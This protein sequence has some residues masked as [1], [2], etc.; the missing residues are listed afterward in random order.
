SFLSINENEVSDTEAE[1][2]NV[3]PDSQHVL[4]PGS[5]FRAVDRTV[6]L[7]NGD[8]VTSQST[9]ANKHRD[10]M[11]VVT[12]TVTSVNHTIAQKRSIT[13]NGAWNGRTL[14]EAVAMEYGAGSPLPNVT[15]GSLG[16][17][18][19]GDDDSVPP[20]FRAEPVPAP[21]R[22]PLSLDGVA[23]V[24]NH[25]DREVVELA[26]TLRND[27][28]DPE[29]AFW[30]S[31]QLSERLQRWRTQ[32][33]EGLP[34]IETAE[35]LAKLNFG[36]PS[37]DLP[38]FD[39]ADLAALQSAFGYLDA[40]PLQSQAA[41]AYLLLKHG[42]S[43][44]VTLSPNWGLIAH[45][46]SGMAPGNPVVLNPPLSFDYSHTQHRTTQ[47]IMWQR[48]LDTI[49]S[50]HDLL[51]DAEH[52]QCP[53][54][55]LMDHTLIYL[56]TDFG[57]TKTHPAGATEW[58][59]GHELNNGSLIVSSLT[60]G[61][62]VLGGVEPTTGMTFGWNPSNGNDLP[63]EVTPEGTVYAGILQALDVDTAG[64]GLP[65]VPVMSA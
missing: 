44:A 60:P 23:G 9:F 40:D 5:D 37:A 3:I 18:A 58:G 16:F 11:L 39:P 28:L 19:D 31:F 55:S 47:A 64:S 27:R 12:Q 36:L 59:S 6:S 2:L 7:F 26:R 54:E 34:Q 52:P 50:L 17:R 1:T 21:E 62:T 32:R 15:M 42:I 35:L 46:E 41:L 29:S 22:W 30:G 48:M 33:E 63:E 53:G 57:R 65:A 8:H 25:P 13:G 24:E 56:A 4:I 14:Q 20:E 61:N 38:D 10:R 51:D 49:D 43:N 45:P